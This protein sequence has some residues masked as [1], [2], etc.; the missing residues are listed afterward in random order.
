MGPR[1]RGVRT[2]RR[3]PGT[4]SC[5]EVVGPRMAMA[6]YHSYPDGRRRLAEA[7]HDP[8]PPPPPPTPGRERRRGGERGTAGQNASITF[9]VPPARVRLRSLGGWVGQAPS[10]EKKG[11]R[12]LIVEEK[13]PFGP[14]TLPGRR[15][16]DGL[17][18]LLQQALRRG[19]RIFGIEPLPRPEEPSPPMGLAAAVFA[20]RTLRGDLET[21]QVHPTPSRSTVAEDA[22]Y[23]RTGGITTRRPEAKIDV[24]HLPD[25][26]L[27]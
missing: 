6:N 13:A 25:P 17:H 20:N 4:T 19:A 5:L 8:P 3:L 27:R 12:R 24:R 21:V 16:R 9:A 22:R 11:G 2:Q 10:R 15:S 23:R 26:L 18:A 7:L 1:C 14:R